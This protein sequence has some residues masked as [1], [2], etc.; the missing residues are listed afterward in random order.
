[1]LL[2]RNRLGLSGRC[3][4][5]Q[6]IM[7]FQ[8]S[9]DVGPPI[10]NYCVFIYNLMTYKF[11]WYKYSRCV[12]RLDSV[13]VPQ[14]VLINYMLIF[15]LV[16]W[17]VQI[18]TPLIN[19]YVTC[20]SI[21]DRY[22]SAFLSLSGLQAVYIVLRKTPGRPIPPPFIIMKFYSAGGSQPS[23]QYGFLHAFWPL[24]RKPQ[25]RRA[26]RVRKLTLLWGSSVNA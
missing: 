13:F 25:S 2:R 22:L 1:M 23:H 12:C 10:Q 4:F 16:G 15:C 21:V 11:A 9:V 3:W 24:N 19:H 14:S 6:K 18:E 26:V 17:H 7:Q 8:L 5:T 20:F